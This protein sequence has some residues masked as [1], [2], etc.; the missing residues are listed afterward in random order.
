MILIGA[1]KPH[2][3]HRFSA[4]TTIYREHFHIIDGFTRGVNGNSFDR[5]RHLYRGITSFKNKHYHRFYG[6]TGP[7]IPLPGG[8]HYHL[9]EDRT[10]YNYD[11]PIDIEY[12][13]VLYGEG[14]RPKH[15]HRFEGRTYGI[16]GEDPLAR[17]SYTDMATKLIDYNGIRE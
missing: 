12:G 4:F 9:F 16:V 7:A 10:Y 1:D 13:G 8:G 5:H 2:H 17:M 11:E 6:E 14:E 3:A 15:D